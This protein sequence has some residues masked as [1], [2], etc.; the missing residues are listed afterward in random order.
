MTRVEKGERKI[1]SLTS[2]NY[3]KVENHLTERMKLYVGISAKLKNNM[4]EIK[5]IE[6][7]REWRI[8]A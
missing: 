1:F 7:E 5:H 4:F 2:K 3:K 8:E 6:T